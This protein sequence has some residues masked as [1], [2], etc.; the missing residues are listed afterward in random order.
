MVNK[1]PFT[2]FSSR[3]SAINAAYD[4]AFIADTG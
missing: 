1:W 2:I 3:V 4:A